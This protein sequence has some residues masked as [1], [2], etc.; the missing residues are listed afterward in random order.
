MKLVAWVTSCT[1]L[2][3]LLAI[4][5]VFAETSVNSLKEVSVQ[6][7]GDRSVVHIV[8]DQ[9]VGYRYTVYDSNDPIRVVVDFPRMNLGD[10]QSPIKVEQ[11]PLQE[12]RL[13]TFDLSLGTLARVEMLLD[14]DSEYRVNFAGND[15][16][17]SF[18]ADSAAKIATK[19]SSVPAPAA[20]QE[21]AVQEAAV[22]EAAVQEAAVQE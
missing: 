3:T 19:T 10:L 11:A 22:Q 15:M 21:A 1:I 17:I 20:V 8:T 9:S 13:S 4:A 18:A 12:I 14:K 6:T 5:P 7:E 2:L 16:Q